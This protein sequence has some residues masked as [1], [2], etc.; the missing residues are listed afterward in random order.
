MLSAFL[1]FYFYAPTIQYLRMSEAPEIKK[2]YEENPFPPCDPDK[3][4]SAS[5]L[6]DRISP[7]YRRLDESISSDQSVL[8]A[9]CGTGILS[10]FLALKGREVTGIDISSESL[11]IARAVKENIGIENAEYVQKDLMDLDMSEDYDVVISLGVLQHLK[12]PYRGF[13]I[14]SDHVKQGGY[15][16]CGTYNTYG[17]VQTNLR[18]ILFQLTGYRFKQV[19][20][21]LQKAPTE[22]YQSVVFNDQYLNPLDKT[23]TVG[24]ILD[25][26]SSNNLE[27]VRC[28]PPLE[29]DIDSAGTENIFDSAEIHDKLTRTIAQA[30]WVFSGAGGYGLFVM[31]GRN[32]ERT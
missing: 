4:S 22:N 26:F 3:V 6:Y 17:R 5:D 29:K 28:V 2:F 1:C 23:R 30:K 10:N 27:F 20:Q 25:W 24:E 14:I 21:Y 9:G 11:K 32:R 31:I 15:M 8:I 18:K 12:A 7:F 16:V 19:D 13:E